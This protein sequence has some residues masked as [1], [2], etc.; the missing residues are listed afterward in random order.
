LKCSLVCEAG[1]G[2]GKKLVIRGKKRRKSSRVGSSR[3]QE[4]GREKGGARLT[5]KY[6]T[7]WNGERGGER[8]IRDV[9]KKK[10]KKA[11]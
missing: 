1:K 4:G 7:L 5:W 3:L 2:R 10:T 9:G 8:K 11:G 6:R